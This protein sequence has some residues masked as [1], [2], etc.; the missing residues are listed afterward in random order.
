M[1]MREGGCKVYIISLGWNKFIVMTALFML[2]TIN[3]SLAWLLKWSFIWTFYFHHFQHFG[4]FEWWR[5]GLERKE[6]TNQMRGIGYM[7]HDGALL[8]APGYKWR[9]SNLA[10][11]SF[12]HEK[13]ILLTGQDYWGHIPFGFNF[14]WYLSQESHRNNLT[15]NYSVNFRFCTIFYPVA[16]LPDT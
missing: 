4:W 5:V 11:T 13:C 6:V 7:V 1:T 10:T 12:G 16:S 9:H 14:S 15:F 2:G 8:I 3:F